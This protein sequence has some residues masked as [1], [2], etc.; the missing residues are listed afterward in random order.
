LENLEKL[1]YIDLDHN[2]LPDNLKKID[3][4]A[5]YLKEYCRTGELP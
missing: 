2:P 1:E 3:D 4:D 5:F